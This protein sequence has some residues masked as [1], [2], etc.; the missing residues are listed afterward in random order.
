MCYCCKIMKSSRNESS[1]F[2]NRKYAKNNDF[3]K[4]ISRIS[5]DGHFEGDYGIFM[6]NEKTFDFLY[7]IR[8]IG[9]QHLHFRQRWHSGNGTAAAGDDSG[10]FVGKSQNFL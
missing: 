9:L 7:L 6:Y 10:G 5:K 8:A 3:S 2:K 4:R 1:K